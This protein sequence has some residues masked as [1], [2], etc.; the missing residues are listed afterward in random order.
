MPHLCLRLQ[1][2]CKENSMSPEIKKAVQTVHD[3]RMR[4]ALLDSQRRVLERVA[5]GAP[6]ED[7]LLTLVRLIEEQ[8]S[9]M[10]C[11]V[12]LADAAQTRLRFAAGPS[13]TNDFRIAIEPYLVIGPNAAPCGRAAFFKQPVYVRDLATEAA[14]ESFND[15]ALANGVR[16]AWSTPILSDEN[17]VLGTFAMFYGEPR[18][19][20]EEH[21]QLIDMAVQMARVAIEAKADEEML[22]LV[23]DHAPRPMMILDMEG[24][25]ARANREFGRVLGYLPEDLRGKRVT[26][27]N[28]HSDTVAR[29]REL[30]ASEGEVT[31]SARYRARDGRVVWVRERSSVRRDAMGEPK[32][33]VTR[34]DSLSETGVDPLASLSAREREVL[35]LVV[36]G[37]T[38][39][40]IG[41]RLHISPA[42][43]E[44]YR[45]RIMAKLAIENLPSLVRFAIRHGVCPM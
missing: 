18:L 38:S 16:A 6:L 35:T 31:G 12:L 24:H 13:L 29:M 41:R 40:D 5:T 44:T 7:V 43:V 32:Y 27:I 39:K 20:D 33:I 4:A 19:P 15:I 21:I 23:F 11:S 36:S 37:A 25:I 2:W 3:P 22:R 30:D 42:T 9:G 45:S 1:I 10:R 14:W 17:R 8:A 26:E 34:V 28:V